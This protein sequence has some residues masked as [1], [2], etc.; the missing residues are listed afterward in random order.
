MTDVYFYLCK[1]KRKEKEGR[2]DAGAA[3]SQEMQEVMRLIKQ[4]I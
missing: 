2:K 3:V 1:S 4:E